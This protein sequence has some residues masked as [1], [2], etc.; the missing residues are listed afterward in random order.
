MWK[1]CTLMFFSSCKVQKGKTM[2][3]E[4]NSIVNLGRVTVSW[5]AQ[6]VLSSVCENLSIYKIMICTL[7]YMYTVLQ[8]KFK[9]GGE[10][11]IFPNKTKHE[12]TCCQQTWSKRNP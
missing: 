2:L 12:I 6:V 7:S 1:K 4:V 11:N 9:K 5:L 8:K 3:F 10:I